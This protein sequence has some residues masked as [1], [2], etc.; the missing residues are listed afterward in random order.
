MLASFLMKRSWVDTN[1]ELLQWYIPYCFRRRQRKH[2][3]K[4]IHYAIFDKEKQSNRHWVSFQSKQTKTKIY[5]GK[6]PLATT[7]PPISGPVIKKK[8]LIFS[9]TISGVSHV[10]QD[11]SVKAFS[12]LP[13]RLRWQV[14]YDLPR[15]LY[16]T[17]CSS[18]RFKAI[19][20]KVKYSIC[21]VCRARTK[22]ESNRSREVLDSK[23]TAVH[24]GVPREKE[25]TAS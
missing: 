2:K 1:Y 4:R 12:L 7:A 17:P 5:Q 13:L 11:K 20:N 9:K 18:M 15:K 22:G 6:L 23:D 24:R 19:L 14:F 8:R 16:V 3:V 21:T 10:T 25:K